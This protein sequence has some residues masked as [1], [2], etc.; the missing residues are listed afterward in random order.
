[1]AST[2]ARLPADFQSCGRVVACSPVVVDLHLDR[3]VV[4]AVEWFGHVVIDGSFHFCDWR[5]FV[6]T[7]I[8]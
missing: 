2:N 4:M 5:I 1:M 3:A 8:L 6:V 7:E